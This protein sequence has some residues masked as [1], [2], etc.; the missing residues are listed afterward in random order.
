MITFAGSALVARAYDLS[1]L[2]LNAVGVLAGPGAGFTYAM[3]SIFGKRALR[4]YHPA[5]IV[6]FAL[7][8][9]ALCLVPFQSA[10]TLA[11]ALTPSPLWIWLVVM[12]AG[13]T[14]GSFTLYTMGL[15]HIQASIASIVA[16][17]EPATAAVLS[18]VV[19]HEQFTPGQAL[20]GALIL[21][22]VA[23][24]SLAPSSGAARQEFGP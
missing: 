17:L 24:L 9:G 1:Q 14:I 21:A 11:P 7:G 8:F 22:G 13:P 19:L 18:F 3:Y 4:S 2:R 20:G 23:L 10:V 12:A 5:T 15:R 6:T 16:M